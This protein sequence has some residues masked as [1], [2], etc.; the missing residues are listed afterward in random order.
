[1]EI[2]DRLLEDPSVKEGVFYPRRR[3]SKE[4]PRRRRIHF[5]NILTAYMHKVVYPV[6]SFSTHTL[7]TSCLPLADTDLHSSPVR[8]HPHITR[9]EAAN[10]I[11]ITEESPAMT[12]RNPSAVVSSSLPPLAPQA[13]M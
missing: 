1:M 3:R 6:L 2:I 8:V 4:K 5:A 9:H 12:S 11:G 13:T 10:P 7:Y